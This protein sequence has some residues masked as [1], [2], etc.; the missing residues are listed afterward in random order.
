MKQDKEKN[1]KINLEKIKEIE[2]K[3][4]REKNE[5]KKKIS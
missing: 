1:D 4:K 5:L 2:N 3:Y